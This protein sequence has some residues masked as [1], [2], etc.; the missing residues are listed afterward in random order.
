MSK[1]NENAEDTYKSKYETLLKEAKEKDSIIK[2]LENENKRLKFC[3]ARL[4]DI[5]AEMLNGD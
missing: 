3:I 2:H 5:A 4:R 1:K